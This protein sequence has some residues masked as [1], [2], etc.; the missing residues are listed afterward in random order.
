[1]YAVDLW[2]MELR[3]RSPLSASSRPHCKRLLE[4]LAI[5]GDEYNL[6]L[7][8]FNIGYVVGQYPGTLLTVKVREIQ[9]LWQPSH[10]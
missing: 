7:T 9:V 4:D 8:M 10:V 5:E 1:M 3:R 2:A 6:L